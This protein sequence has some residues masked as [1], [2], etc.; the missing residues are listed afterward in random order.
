MARLA[1]DRFGL[2]LLS[3][4]AICDAIAALVLAPP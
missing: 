1:L 2:V 3:A 4:F